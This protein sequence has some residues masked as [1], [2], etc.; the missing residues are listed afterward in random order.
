M[1][2]AGCLPEFIALRS[3]AESLIAAGFQVPIP[4]LFLV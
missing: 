2:A 4:A 1:N 3:Q